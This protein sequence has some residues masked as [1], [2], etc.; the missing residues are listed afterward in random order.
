M[1]S[2]EP[3]PE[4]AFASSLADNSALFDYFPDRPV[5]WWYYGPLETVDREKGPPDRPPVPPK[6]GP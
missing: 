5:Y 3:R 2:A 1:L 4:L 6:R